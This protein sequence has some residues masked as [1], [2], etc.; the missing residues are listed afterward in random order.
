MN[1][2]PNSDSNSSILV[3]NFD[4]LDSLDQ[5]EKLNVIDDA[6]HRLNFERRLA[7]LSKSQLK[8]L[9]NENLN[10]AQRKRLEGCETKEQYDNVIEEYARNMYFRQCA[11]GDYLNGI[12]KGVPCE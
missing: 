10:N 12:D 4:A 1:Q 2:T 8:H 9:E 5:K 11:W 7:A 6:L 3:C